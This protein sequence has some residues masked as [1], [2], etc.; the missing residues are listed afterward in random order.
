MTPSHRSSRR[1]VRS[2]ATAVPLTLVAV[3][4]LA[5]CSSDDTTATDA[6]AEATTSSSATAGQV[7]VT[8]VAED[9]VNSCQLDSSTAQAGPITFTVTNESSTAI[10]EVELL[11]DERIRGEKENLAPGL[12]A[13]SFTVTLTGGTYQLYCPG[14][15][16]ELQDFTVEGEAVVPTG[17]TQDLL[18]EGI[19][20]YHEYVT[21]QVSMMLDAVTTLQTAVDSGDVEA[22]KEAYGA[23]RPYY[24]RIESSVEGFILPG[25]D[26]TDNS[27]NLDYLIDMRASNLDEEVGWHGFH[28][29]ERDLWENGAITDDTKT[30]AAELVENVTTLNDDVV[31]TLEFLP[32][33]LANGAA[34]LLEEVQTNKITG[35]EEEFSHLDLVDFAGNVEGAEQAFANLKAG[36]EEIDPDLTDDVA[37]QFAA[38]D[39]LL[40]NY[41]DTTAIGGYVTYTAELQ[42]SDAQTLTTAIQALHDPLSQIAEKVATAA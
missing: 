34:S 21:D 37:A 35:E 42:A 4:A 24:E 7:A 15:D 19:E 20:G 13:V 5:A 33:D 32:E 25:T 38:V 14:A 16:T 12:D 17:G 11:D 28:A 22:A 9:G 29:I 18:T 27:E 31:P 6:S 40:E 1:A 41:K 23:A 26:A 8:L 30:Q 3:L 36:L 10:S 39:A 2:A